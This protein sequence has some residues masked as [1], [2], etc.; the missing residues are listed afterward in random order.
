MVWLYGPELAVLMCVAGVVRHDTRGTIT[1]KIH[2][3]MM[4]AFA[5]VVASPAVAIVN[6]PVASNAYIVFGGLD[7]AWASLMA[8]V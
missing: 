6:M 3:M 4:A 1:M 8:Q 5:A 2:T 7:W